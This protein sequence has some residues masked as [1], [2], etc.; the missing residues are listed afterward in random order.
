MKVLLDMT[1][2]L[3]LMKWKHMVVQQL[4]DHQNHNRWLCCFYTAN[5]KLQENVYYLQLV[6]KLNLLSF[7][8]KSGQL[9]WEKG[10]ENSSFIL[11]SLFNSVYVQVY[12]KPQHQTCAEQVVGVIA[13]AGDDGHPAVS[14]LSGE[15]SLR[16]VYIFC[17][18]R[19]K[20]SLKEMLQDYK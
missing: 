4:I 13:P 15:P 14:R 5:D 16:K 9:C 12:W 3:S 19:G 17:W 20:R 10:S 2:C 6:D 7:T 1:F 18:S 11:I 8:D